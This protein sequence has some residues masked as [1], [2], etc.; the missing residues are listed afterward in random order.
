MVDGTAVLEDTSLLA[1]VVVEE[2]AG[3]KV[4]VVGKSPMEPM[5]GFS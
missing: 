3:A 2:A 1:S 4:E 5:L